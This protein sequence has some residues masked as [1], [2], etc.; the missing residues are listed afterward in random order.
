MLL[1]SRPH[2]IVCFALSYMHKQ[3]LRSLKLEISFQGG[4][5][6]NLHLHLHLH[7]QKPLGNYDGDKYVHAKPGLISTCY[8]GDS[9]K[10]SHISRPCSRYFL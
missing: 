1:A 6:Q 3:L 10:S 5:I 7:R 2:V 4:N 9:V 8:W